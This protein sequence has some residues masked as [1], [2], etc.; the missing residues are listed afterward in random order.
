MTKE[1]TRMMRSGSL[2][3]K[4]LMMSLMMRRLMNQSISLPAMFLE[5][6]SQ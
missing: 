2:T 6:L 3:G 1:M 4:L 5:R